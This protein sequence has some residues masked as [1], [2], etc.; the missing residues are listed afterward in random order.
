MGRINFLGKKMADRNRQAFTIVPTNHWGWPNEK[1]I[2]KDKKDNPIKN[3]SG[4]GAAKLI[5][6]LRENDG[7]FW[8]IYFI[9]LFYQ[10][11]AEKAILVRVLS[12]SAG[13]IRTYD[14]RINSPLRYRCATAECA[15]KRQLWILYYFFIIFS[16]FISNNL[17]V[18]WVLCASGFSQ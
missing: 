12:G 10:K 5:G 3:K 11:I 8:S 1:E 16:I 9:I 14:Q 18:F 7:V 6:K 15:A 4:I 13:R 17:S 2:E